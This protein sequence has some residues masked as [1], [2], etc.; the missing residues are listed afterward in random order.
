MTTI[1]K[2]IG[3]YMLFALISLAMLANLSYGA[4]ANPARDTCSLYGGQYVSGWLGINFIVIIVT[5]SL[6]GMFY[7]IS[8]FLNEK[9]KA[10]ASNIVKIEITQ[11]VISIVL[12][13]ILLTT[14]ETACSI[15]QNIGKLLTGQSMDP[16]AYSIYYVGNSLQNIGFPLVENIYIKALDLAITSRVWTG[17]AS[18][19]P[20][21]PIPIG[22][23]IIT[24]SPN[25]DPAMPIG[26]LADLYIG[27]FI[28]LMLVPMG[29]LFLLYLTLPILRLTAF[30][31]I[32]PVALIVRSFGF[33]S[34]GKLR[35]TADAMI[36]ISIAAYIIF[37]L[38]I[39][40]NS[41]VISWIFTPCSANTNVCN[42]Y[43]SFV[44]MSYNIQ[45]ISTNQFFTQKNLL[46]QG[47][48]KL[49]VNALNLLSA[50]QYSNFFS[51][52]SA[53]FYDLINAPA[54]TQSLVNQMAEFMF[55]FVIMFGIDLTVT[56]GFAM[57]LAHA[58]SG[59]VIGPSSFWNNV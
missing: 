59:G 56:V 34:S 19:M 38:M 41:Y 48:I 46:E 58:L 52:L 32:L 33:A 40:F 14:S 49:P 26:I 22:T 27:I 13:L 55:S 21:P 12:I 18:A 35:E 2:R 36:A 7:S 25:G 9:A 39:E 5:I 53:V 4:A 37:P 50:T 1:S 20:L 57:S 28:P 29:M 47:G 43:W 6:A 54:I 24:L 23:G 16:F 8:R 3:L 42:P 17:I 30:T 11:S 45:S 15:S 51:G 44:G 31:V 10:A